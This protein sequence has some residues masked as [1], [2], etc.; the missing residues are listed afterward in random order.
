MRCTEWQAKQLVFGQ[1][2]DEIGTYFAAHASV[3][4]PIK[5]AYLL[6]T[7]AAASIQQ[8]KMRDIDLLLPEN[9][10]AA[11]CAWFAKL[12]GVTEQQSDWEFQHSF[13][14]TIGEYPVYCEFHR[15]INFEARF[16]L[17]NELLFK[18]GIRKSASCILPDP[19]D[20]LL[21]CMCHMLAHVVNG[22][23]KDQYY[24]IFLYVNADGFSW[25]EF[26]VCAEATG[27]MPFIWLVVATCN[28]RYH[29]MFPLPRA[30]SWYAAL[31]DRYDLFMRPGVPVIR[32]LLFEIPFMRDRWWLAR[33]KLKKMLK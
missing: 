21:I 4:M 16:L 24:E 32:K 1:A 9:Q 29:C 17:P 27:I 23:S 22:F 5:G 30:P 31:V 6:Y 10:F 14:Y 3:F 15:L 28:R 2:L 20:A 19:V 26:W 8:R 7:G 13:S 18:R 25:K 11:I 33:Y 12:P